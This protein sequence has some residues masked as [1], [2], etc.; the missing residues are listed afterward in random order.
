MRHIPLACPRCRHELVVSIRQLDHQFNCVECRTPFYVNSTGTCIKGLKPK[1]NSTANLHLSSTRTSSSTSSTLLGKLAHPPRRV[2]YAGIA[3]ALVLSAL[4]VAR[5]LTVASQSIPESL[6]DRADFVA[7]AFAEGNLD[8]ILRVS[9]TGTG[10]SVKRW[11]E[12]KRVP[13]HRIW[14]L[15]P[16]EINTTTI[17]KK[18]SAGSACTLSVLLFPTDQSIT[19]AQRAAADLDSSSDSSAAAAQPDTPPRAR[20]EVVLFWKTDSQNLWVVDGGRT[21]LELTRRR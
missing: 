19:V 17:Y 7:R 2:V 1:H 12:L 3:L 15:G 10:L 9:D 21:V 20:M 16:P 13:T 18:T 14:S 6:E 4:L 5:A 11:F 8:A